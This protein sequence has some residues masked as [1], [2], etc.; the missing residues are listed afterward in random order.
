MSGTAVPRPREGWRFAAVVIT[1]LVA[2][3]IARP[4]AGPAGVARWADR[5]RCRSRAGLVLWLDA[6][7]LAEAAGRPACRR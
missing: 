2:S 7:R 1:A 4:A 6:A 3:G 5:R